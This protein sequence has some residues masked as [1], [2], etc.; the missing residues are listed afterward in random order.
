MDGKSRE[1]LIVK[2]EG[3]K[4]RRGKVLDE[5][6]IPRS[7]YYQWRK[8]YEQ[9]GV[10][11]LKKTKPSAKRIWNRLTAEEAQQ[12]LTIARLHPEL[13][14]R[15]LAVKITDEESFSISESTVYRTLK[16][17][18]LIAPRP[19]PEM[20]AQKQW[21]HKTTH[22]DE[23]WQCDGTNLFVVGWGYYKL[24]PVEDDYSRKIIAHDLRPDETGFNISDIVEM[25]IE[26]ARK[27]GHLVAIM[28]KLYSDNGS[29]FVSKVLAEYLSGHGIKHIFGTPYHP[30]GRGKIERFNRSIK[31]KI[32]LV[33]YSSPE[34]LKKAIDE[35]IAIYNSTPHEALSNVSPNDV[36][37]GR[38]EDILQKRREKK[39]LT[40]ERRRQ[41]NLYGH[42]TNSDD[43]DQ[44]QNANSVPA[45]VSKK[46]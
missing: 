8:A 17:N 22:P 28:P 25:G 29:G 32:C 4:G 14:S 21:R 30:Q 37:A 40:M 13:S 1:D 19:L 7:T 45:N 43:P 6:T 26:N 39:R 3:Q 5:L 31:E 2:V 35:A 16:E 36:Y 24:L 23:L 42:S 44:H 12:V 33:I 38:K 9:K 34:E 46:V 27:E 15:L 41:Y 20:P 10:S 11:G 18:N